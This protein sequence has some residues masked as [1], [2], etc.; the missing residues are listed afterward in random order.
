M[1]AC[2]CGTLIDRQHVGVQ[3]PWFDQK[4]FISRV[5]ESLHDKLLQIEK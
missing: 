2:V 5:L 4:L 1:D 3:Q